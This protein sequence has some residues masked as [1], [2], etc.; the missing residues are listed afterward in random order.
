L[1]LLLLVAVV[2]SGGPAPLSAQ[3]APAGDSTV[4]TARTLI[5]AGR[6]GDAAALLQRIVER[7]PEDARAWYLLGYALHQAGDLD[8]ALEADLRAAR[9]PETAPTA[10]YN[11][12]MAYARKGDVDEAF[13]WLFRA[14]EAGMDVTSAAGDPDAETLRDD[15]RWGRL[16]P[17]SAELADPFEEPVQ[18]IREW[19]GEDAGD[20][21]GWIA[22]NAGDVDGDGVMDVVTSAPTHR[23]GAGAVYVYSTGTGALLWRHVGRADEQLGLGVEAAGD[24]DGDGHPDVVAGA[25]R[26]DRVY[27]LSGPDGRLLLR[28]EGTEGESFGRRAAGVGDVDGDGHADILVGRPANDEAGEDAGAA[29]LFSGVDGR[30]LG[31]LRGEEAGDA[32]GSSLAGETREGETVLVVG[33]PA[34][35]P[36]DRGR[37]Y[38]YDGDGELRF[39]IEADG[40]GVALGRMFSSVVGD[41]DGDGGDD[42]YASDWSNDALGPSTG[43]IYVHSGADGRRLLTLTGEAAGDGFGIGTAEA[44]DLDGDGRDDLVVGAWQHGGGAPGGGKVY[45]FSGADGRLLRSVTGK[46]MGETFGFDATGLGDVD[47]DGAPDLLLTS[48][49]SAV[50]GP[51][52]GRVWVLSGRW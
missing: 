44:G 15:V 29:T 39:R 12:A 35:G 16:F 10:M 21:F 7:D 6:M 11:A 33:A 43:R 45:L 2:V 22:R 5:R 3:V 36:G 38:V 34:A 20:Q 32:F 27:V 4:Q 17:T 41:V 18:V 9:F 23:N 13:R 49:W 42:V 28:L 30:P 46:V 50:N 47:G 31:E 14:R 51:R 48:A 24:V 8:G 26:A 40:T 52:S 37:V 19:R 25:P 1:V